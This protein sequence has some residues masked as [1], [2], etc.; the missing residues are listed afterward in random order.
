M[1]I[2]IQ[3]RFEQAFIQC[4]TDGVHPGPV[5]ITK[6]MGRTPTNHLN[7]RETRLRQELMWAFDVSYKRGYEKGKVPQPVGVDRI[8]LDGQIV[9]LE[10][11]YRRHELDE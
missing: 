3:D 7:G 9:K 5:E 11:G 10:Q 1:G 2:S 8:F 6:R 4:L